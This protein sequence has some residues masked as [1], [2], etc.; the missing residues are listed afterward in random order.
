MFVDL[1]CW[2]LSSVFVSLEPDFP[3]NELIAFTAVADWISLYTI[4][5]DKTIKAKCMDSS[6][7][8]PFDN[9]DCSLVSFYIMNQILRND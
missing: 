3:S 1:W 8:G 5:L 4:N 9:T 6:L 2:L 7:I